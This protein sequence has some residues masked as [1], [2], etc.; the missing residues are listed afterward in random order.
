MDRRTIT[1]LKKIEDTEKSISS[2]EVAHNISKTKEIEENTK[3]QSN[4]IVI[5]VKSTNEKEKKRVTFYLSKETI[6]SI[7]KSA[8][9]SNRSMSEIIEILVEALGK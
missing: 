7:E 6:K 4:R 2:I 1:P 3:S 8:K 5:P 9:V